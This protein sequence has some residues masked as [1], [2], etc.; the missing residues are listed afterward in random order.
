MGAEIQF[1]LL[2]NPLVEFPITGLSGH[3]EGLQA[4][5]LPSS[6]GDKTSL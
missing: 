3:M 2:S 5:C 1:Y 6:V 4:T